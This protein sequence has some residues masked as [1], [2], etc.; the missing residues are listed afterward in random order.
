V[1][2]FLRG[3]VRQRIGQ[4]SLDQQSSDAPRALRITTRT[5]GSGRRAGDTIEPDRQPLPLGDLE[6]FRVV[7]ER[8]PDESRI[9]NLTL[10]YNLGW[11][12]VVLS[13]SYANRDW[14]ISSDLTRLVDI[15]YK[16]LFQGGVDAEV[17]EAKESGVN[18]GCDG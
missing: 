7:E 12:D 9:L 1:L 8:T 14:T 10:N 16:W 3:D 6:Q 17:N 18:P 11:S 15:V 5:R 4:P 13:A 2:A